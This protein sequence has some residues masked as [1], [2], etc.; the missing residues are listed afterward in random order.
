[1]R[2]LLAAAAVLSLASCGSR[3]EGE[4]VERR[5]VMEGLTLSQSE[6]GAPS[7]TL[8][9]PL[10]VL[11]EDSKRATLEKPA[12]EF[13]RGGK[14]VSRVTALGGEVDTATHDVRLSSSVVLDSFDDKSKLTTTELLY[15]A[16]KKKFTTK[17]DILVQRP[18]GVLRGRGMEATPDLTEIRIFN[19][20][21][22]FTGAPN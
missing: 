9:S 5:Q 16:D 1:M 7:W 6:K 13:Y 12:M 22:T 2:P 21:S 4:R 20:Q 17:A 19:Q 3:T 15:S 10:A 11:R 14:A 8:K 18:E